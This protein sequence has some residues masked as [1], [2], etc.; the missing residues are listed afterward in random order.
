MCA[1]EAGR[2]RGGA[3]QVRTGRHDG[4]QIARG[5]AVRRDRRPAASQDTLLAARSKLA[6]AE[7]RLASAHDEAQSIISDAVEQGNLLNANARR[8]AEKLIA[9]SQD[10]A[11]AIEAAARAE[12]E[13]IRLEAK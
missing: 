8:V 4:R 12:V 10:E 7:A 5:P 6:E 13:N 1:V 11:T 2:H 9:E 3:D